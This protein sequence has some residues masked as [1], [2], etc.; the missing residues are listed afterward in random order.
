MLVAS[1][2][3]SGCPGEDPPEDTSPGPDAPGRDTGVFDGGRDAGMDAPV[4]PF[5]GDGNI[6]S[7]ETCDDG[8]E[9]DADGCDSAC[10]PETG[11]TCD[12]ES[13]TVCAAICGDGMRVGAEALAAGCDD[14]GTETRDGCDELCRV[15]PGFSCAGAPSV[16][17]AGC[18]DGIIAGS[19]VCDDGNV[20]DGDGCTSS[21]A[22]EEGWECM[23]MPS[24]CI[25]IGEC[26]DSMILGSEGCDDGNVRDGDGCSITCA[27][28]AGWT[29]AG[30]PTV[31][32]AT[33]GDGMLAAGPASV[34]GAEQCDDGNTTSFDGCHADCR[35]ESEIEPNEDGTPSTGGSGPQGNDFDAVAVTNADAN[36]AID[37]AWEMTGAFGVPGD[38][39]VFAYENTSSVAQTVTFAMVEDGTAVCA[40][41]SA[42][43]YDPVITLRSVDGTQLARDDNA[44]PGNCPLLT[45]A[46]PAGETIYIH[47][48]E[49]G[50]NNVG[51]Y[52]LSI[53]QCPDGIVASSEV[54]DDGNTINGDSC[55][56][57]CTVSACGNGV[58][59]GAESCDDGNLINGDGCDSNCRPTGCGNG[60]MGP[61][62]SCDD[63]DMDSGDGCDSNCTVTACG[64]GIVT[65]GELCDDGNLTSGDGCDMN[66]TVTACG[67]GIR[68]G[69]EYCD[70]GNTTNGDG[71][72]N[73]C[74]IASTCGNGVMNAGETCDDGARVVGDG[75]D[76]YCLREAGFMCGTTFPTSCTAICGD[77]IVAGP[78]V[79]DD[80]NTVGGD[81]CEADCRSSL[82]NGTD[83][84]PNG[85]RASASC[86]AVGALALG[87]VEPTG[88][89]D[90]WRFSISANSNVRVETF[91]SGG[92]ACATIDTI[93]NLYRADGT[94]LVTDD[95]DGV[96][97]CSLIDPSVI[98]DGSA[99]NLA[100]G[101]YYVRVRYASADE[102]G[103]YSL[104]VTTTPGPVCGDGTLAR[105]ELCDDGNTM[106]GD[107]CSATCGFEFDIQVDGTGVPLTIPDGNSTGVTTPATV[108][109]ACT[110]ARTTVSIVMNHTYAGDVVLELISPAGTRVLLQNRLGS[111]ND[112]VGTY[113]FRVGGAPWIPSGSPVPSGVYDAPLG[114]LVGEAGIGTWMLR[115][116][117]PGGGITGSITAWTLGLECM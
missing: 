52:Q 67:N 100:P 28:E 77:G 23:D 60:V 50:D 43:T 54:C 70:D 24:D 101:T 104:R 63:G 16:C 1:A 95:N 112:L 71:C 20:L 55:D 37:E 83:T 90:Y 65:T 81:A 91:D 21:C 59:A 78:E 68:T 105:G 106:A 38:E 61:G 57:N 10:V 48:T 34:P 26:G 92:T 39:D 113:V 115:G 36:G 58:I 86:I 62:E 109:S 88:D 64:N 2:L 110:V 4:G 42:A 107:G 40:T 66:C 96:G 114:V 49:Y 33:C 29:C 22:V 12:T 84:E 18:G 15:E 9:N 76:R 41:G 35:S 5:C 19:E 27:L 69:T 85:T 75:C 111:S 8:N 46:V 73:N 3:L 72:D 32:T 30:E 116:A 74:D 13:P 99:Y 47:V 117:D 94:L 31:C 25:E 6:D 97:N 89:Q 44:G 11:W 87:N 79:C 93:V 17:M 53:S 7:G 103:A 56:N 51:A 45:Y 14:G 82:C 102:V 108:G 98:A 80:G